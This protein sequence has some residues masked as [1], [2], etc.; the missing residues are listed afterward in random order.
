MWRTRYKSFRRFRHQ[1]FQPRLP[2]RSRTS[3]FTR[4]PRHLR[5]HPT[6]RFTVEYTL[7]AS[8]IRSTI[9]TLHSMRFHKVVIARNGQK[10]LSA[11]LFLLHGSW[12]FFVNKLINHNCISTAPLNSFNTNFFFSHNIG[13]LKCY[14]RSTLIHMCLWVLVHVL[15][16]MLNSFMHDLYSSELLTK[17]GREQCR[18]RWVDVLLVK[19]SP[20]NFA[21]LFLWQPIWLS[22]SSKNSLTKPPFVTWEGVELSACSSNKLYWFM[23]AMTECLPVR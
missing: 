3:G 23:N 17:V 5:R 12:K 11:C 9:L 16:G 7:P 21:T 18:V 1:L 8:C 15:W 14:V 20:N 2:H 4:N 19:T 6:G 10:A 22:D 13:F